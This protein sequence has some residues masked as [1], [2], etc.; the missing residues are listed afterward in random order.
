MYLTTPAVTRAV[1]V[2]G[3][4]ET[5]CTPPAVPLELGTGERIIPADLNV[6][7]LQTGVR[8]NTELQAE[9]TAVPN[10]KFGD[11][12]RIWGFQSNGELWLEPRARSLGSKWNWLLTQAD[13][14]QTGNP[15]VSGAQCK[16]NR[17]ELTHG[18]QKW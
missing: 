14:P 13:Q 6:Q 15:I 11:Q 7:G 3:Q 18:P 1:T 2:A 12:I 4:G 10:I 9:L 5:L 17:E 16:E 8:H